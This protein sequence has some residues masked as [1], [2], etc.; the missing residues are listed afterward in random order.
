MTETL[1][2]FQRAGARLRATKSIQDAVGETD[3]AITRLR[4]VIHQERDAGSDYFLADE[5]FGDAD[6]RL[7]A[8][9]RELRAA[10]ALFEV[11]LSRLPIE[12]NHE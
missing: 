5:M 3:A 2:P 10:A 9:A 11:A 7:V 8:A 4:R 12:V 6:M 1:T